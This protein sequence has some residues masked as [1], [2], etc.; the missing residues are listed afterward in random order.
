M[1]AGVTLSDGIPRTLL[2]VDAQLLSGM[3]SKLETTMG[4]SQTVLSP[5]MEYANLEKSLQDSISLLLS[6]KC[7]LL[8]F[9][10]DQ[11]PKYLFSEEL[12]ERCLDI[13]KLSLETLVLPLVE[14]C[15]SITPSGIAHDLL[16]GSVPSSLTSA[17]DS[18]MHHVCSALTLLEPLF[19]LTSITIPE[20]LMIRCVYIALS[21]L[22]TQD[23]VIP[24][25]HAL[26][27]I[28]I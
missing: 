10:V 21:P 9:S 28:H 13:L 17:L 20:A 14:A 6:A 25:K 16:R 19:S 2:D 26:S 15:A 22:F 7:C 4:D 5:D 24:A 3:L 1:S 23:R 8:T 27:L 12:L 11:L 18:H